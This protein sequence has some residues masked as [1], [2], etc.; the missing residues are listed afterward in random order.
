MRTE[1][2][3]FTPDETGLLRGVR[4][5]RKDAI[6]S[7]LLFLILTLGLSLL[8]FLLL[9][10]TVPWFGHNLGMIA[11]ALA[12]CSAY[13]LWCERRANPHP[14]RAA[15]AKDLELGLADVEHY[16][17]TDALLIEEQ[18]D[19]G[20]AYYLRLTDGRVL[21]LQGQYLYDD[22]EESFPCETLCIAR[23]RESRMLLSF[24]PAGR[25]IAVSGRLP[26]F[27]TGDWKAGRVPEDGA[28]LDVDFEALKARAEPVQEERA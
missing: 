4:G 9:Q 28:L 16:D 8:P 13:A 27:G 3:A 14:W 24:E 5:T 22:E 1:T 15:A 10:G 11:G 7:A 19:E 25:R 17:I 23:A 21:F 20:P 18:E 2:R 6:E 26:A 12:V